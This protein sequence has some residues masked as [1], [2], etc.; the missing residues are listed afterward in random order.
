MQYARVLAPITR[1]GD[2]LP[3]EPQLTSSWED[4]PA[5]KW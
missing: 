4:W 2:V 5:W 1:P 3:A